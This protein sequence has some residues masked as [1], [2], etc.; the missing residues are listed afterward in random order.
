MAHIMSAFRLYAQCALL[1]VCLYMSFCTAVLHACL[2][3]LMKILFLSV[4]GN[5]WKGPLSSENLS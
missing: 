3:T 4:L 1:C 2:L 5:C